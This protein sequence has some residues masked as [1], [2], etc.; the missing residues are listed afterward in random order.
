[1]FFVSDLTVLQFLTISSSGCVMLSIKMD[2]N[3]GLRVRLSTKSGLNTLIDKE[4]M[5]IY[6]KPWNMSFEN[7]VTTSS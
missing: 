2:L 3:R 1:M 4:A 6:R 5:D 7:M